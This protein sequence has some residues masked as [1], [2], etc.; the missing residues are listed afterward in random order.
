MELKKELIEKLKSADSL[1]FLPV[2]EF[3]L[4]AELRLLEEK[5]DYGISLNPKNLQILMPL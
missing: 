3:P 5:T 1:L 2:P 4:K